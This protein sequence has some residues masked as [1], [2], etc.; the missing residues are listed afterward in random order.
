MNTWIC[1]SNPDHVC[2]NA[3]YLTCCHALTAQ[4]LL[5]MCKNNMLREHAGFFVLSRRQIYFCNTLNNKVCDVAKTSLT[6]KPEQQQETCRGREPT[7][8][9]Y[10]RV[11]VCTMFVRTEVCVCVCVP[12]SHGGVYA[13]CHWSLLCAVAAP[14][15]APRDLWP[16]SC[17]EGGQW[18]QRWPSMTGC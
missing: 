10:V 12:Q 17:S 13:G 14:C 3:E 18:P 7:R 1:F 8:T 6:R 16:L 2:Q 4:V 11:C 9:L 15:L 5:R